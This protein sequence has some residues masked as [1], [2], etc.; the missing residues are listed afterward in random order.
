MGQMRQISDIHVDVPSVDQLTVY[1]LDQYSQSLV[2]APYITK[3]LP[4]PQ[5]VPPTYSTI[6]FTD[7]DNSGD[8]PTLT[9][10]SVMPGAT[11]TE[12]WRVVWSDREQSWLVTGSQS[13]NKKI[14]DCWTILHLRSRGDTA[15]N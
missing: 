7:V 10:D 14:E 5:I 3:M 9:I 13:G 4:E 12:E 11:T 1:V 15:I 6:E 8:T 2:I